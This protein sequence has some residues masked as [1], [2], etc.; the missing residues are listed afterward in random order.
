MYYPYDRGVTISPM[1]PE[2]TPLAGDTR[3]IA[4]ETYRFAFTARSVRVFYA[5][6]GH[7]PHSAVSCCG[8][9]LVG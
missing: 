1:V 6:Y 9:R 4:P 7:N 5:S 8:L 3:P 2:A